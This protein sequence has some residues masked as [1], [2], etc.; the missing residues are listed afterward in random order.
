[1]KDHLLTETIA[2]SNGIF[3]H[4]MYCNNPFNN[5]SWR[6]DPVGF[7][8]YITISCD[9][10]GREHRFKDKNIHTIEDLIERIQKKSIS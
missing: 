8:S 2:K 6:V 9:S 1:V 4:C 10:C 7:A 3:E 5:N